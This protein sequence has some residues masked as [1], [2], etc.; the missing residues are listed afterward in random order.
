MLLKL[1]KKVY[2]NTKGKNPRL[3][4]SF[5]SSSEVLRESRKP[6]TVGSFHISRRTCH[7][8]A[9]KW[10]CIGNDFL[11]FRNDRIS[12]RKSYLRSKS[13]FQKKYFSTKYVWECSCSYFFW[14]MF[15][16]LY[17]STQFNA[18]ILNFTLVFFFKRV[19]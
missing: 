2:T 5:G 8:L 1:K 16:A 17:H 13:F 14:K 7:F 10:P 15:W 12:L 18:L 11:L 6:L 3:L 19:I 4:E 9:Q